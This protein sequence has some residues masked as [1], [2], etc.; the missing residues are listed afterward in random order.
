MAKIQWLVCAYMTCCVYIQNFLLQSSPPEFCVT[1]RTSDLD[2]ILK[3]I[4]A[5]E[6]FIY[7]AVMDYFPA[8]IYNHPK[9]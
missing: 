4:N 9:L 8:L 5:S 7:I 6:E 1:P 3:V 2:A